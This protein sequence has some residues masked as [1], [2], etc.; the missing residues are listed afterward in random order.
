MPLL[1]L[2]V[3][4]RDLWRWELEHSREVNATLVLIAHDFAAWDRLASD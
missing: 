4:D 1:L 2:Y 3:Q